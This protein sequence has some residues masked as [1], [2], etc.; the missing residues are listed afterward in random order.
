MPRNKKPILKADKLTIKEKIGYAMGSLPNGF[1]LTFLGQ[2]QAFYYWWMGLDPRWIVIAQILYA[3][4]NVVNDPIFGL[5]QDRTR[6]KSGRYIPWIKVC[7]PI[8]SLT[9]IMI[10]LPP[11]SW[12]SSEYEITLFLWY[13]FSQMAYDTMFTII[14]LAYVALLPQMTMDTG[15]RTKLSVIS[16]IFTGVGVLASVYIPAAYLTDPNGTKIFHF[17]IFVLIFAGIALVPWFFLLRWVKEKHEYIPPVDYPVLES[18]EAVFKNP[19][20]RIYIIYDGI[21]VGILN[22]LGTSALFIFGFSFGLIDENPAYATDNS[23]YLSSQVLP[24]FIF[25]IVCIIAGIFIEIELQKRSDIKTSLWYSMIM[26]AIGFFIAFIGAL[27]SHDAPPNEWAPPWNLWLL[28]IG[29]GIAC[30]GFTGDFI[31]HNPMRA[32]T[33]DYDEL[34]TGERRESVYA[35]VGCIFSKPMISVALAVVP[36]I[37]SI[38]GLQTV[39]PENPV[40][41]ATRVTGTYPG[42]LTGVAIVGF[43]IPSILAAIGAIVWYWY[44]LNKKVIMEMRAKLQKLHEIKRNERLNEDGTSKYVK[45]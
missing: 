25:P 18:L 6:R 26:E 19:S 23:G 9:F 36:A 20:G 45:T 5:L 42:V 1:F 15:E 14:Y 34:L 37:L 11:P 31:Y 12:R 4:W 21:S 13:L 32:D 8:F 28:S 35:G 38:F 40:E 27:P 30:L 2:I 3:I 44:P 29:F 7:A 10:F 33:I 16:A 43:L 17:Q 24:Y 41:A 22:F 39:D